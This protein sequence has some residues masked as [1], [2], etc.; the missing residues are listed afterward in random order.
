MQGCKLPSVPV[1]CWESTAPFPTA[2]LALTPIPKSLNPLRPHIWLTL[3]AED[4]IQMLEHSY[5]GTTT[6]RLMGGG[7]RVWIWILAKLK[8][9]WNE[10]NAV[11]RKFT[12][13]SQSSDFDFE[14]AESWMRGDGNRW[15]SATATTRRRSASTRTGASAHPNQRKQ[16]NNI[17]INSNN[18]ILYKLKRTN[19]METAVRYTPVSYF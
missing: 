16:R 12:L 17:N 6:V 1:S 4:D 9:S 3:L 7:E 11:S 18:N 10:R 5:P 13:V 2:L 8:N 19:Q 15:A 14:R